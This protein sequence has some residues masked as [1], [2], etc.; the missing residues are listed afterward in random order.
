MSY[1]YVIEHV[2]GTSNAWADW[3]S[4]WAC[5]PKTTVKLK[6]FA[7]KKGKRQQSLTKPKEQRAM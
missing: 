3:L 4:R 6:R 2:D 5:Q 1:R 7:R